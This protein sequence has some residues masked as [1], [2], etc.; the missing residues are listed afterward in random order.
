MHGFEFRRLRFSHIK[1]AVCSFTCGVLKKPRLAQPETIQCH[2]QEASP[3]PREGRERSLL[4]S[5]RVSRQKRER[6]GENTP[7]PCTAF[8]GF[9]V[10]LL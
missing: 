9:T 6:V 7:L 5:G 4:S 8:Y 3:G 10:Y 2:T 1:G